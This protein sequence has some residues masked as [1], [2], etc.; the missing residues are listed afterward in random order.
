MDIINPNAAGIA[1]GRRSHFVAINQDHLHVREFGVYA[2]DLK[3]LVNCL[4]DN[5]V[6]TVA[7]ESKG[8]YWQ[9]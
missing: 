8:S 9:N 5:N 2:K 4:L 6:K 3:E 7:M 1:T